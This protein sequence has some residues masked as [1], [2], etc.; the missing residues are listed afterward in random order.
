MRS[1]DGWRC[2]GAQL[3]CGL[4]S[5]QTSSF[6]H[7]QHFA[8]WYYL[9]PSP[10]VRA[11]SHPRNTLTPSALCCLKCQ[12]PTSPMVSCSLSMGMLCPSLLCP[13]LGGTPGP[14]HPLHSGSSFQGEITELMS[15]SLVLF[16]LRLFWIIPI[17]FPPRHFGNS[18]FFP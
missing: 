6:A 1:S 4:F 12:A 11:A 5:P 16:V 7:Q 15:L 17:I 10:F 9:L 3:T 2:L 14:W 18:V 8:L 13:H